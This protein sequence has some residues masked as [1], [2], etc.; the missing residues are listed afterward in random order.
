MCLFHGARAF[1]RRNEKSALLAQ[2]NTGVE[3]LVTG[4]VARPDLPVA[5][6]VEGPTGGHKVV[7]PLGVVGQPQRDECVLAATVK[8]ADTAQI[9]EVLFGDL[10]FVQL[11]VV[12]N[13]HGA[14]EG[15]PGEHPLVIADGVLPIS[16]HVHAAA[17]EEVGQTG[18]ERVGHIDVQSRWRVQRMSRAVR[19]APAPHLHTQGPTHDIVVRTL[20]PVG[21]AHLVQSALGHVVVGPVDVGWLAVALATG[22]QHQTVVPLVREAFHLAHLT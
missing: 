8:E 10:P 5:V 2:S 7:I 22:E 17:L 12:V 9:L 4:G 19:E 16:Q 1:V 11:V 13:P 15:I 14:V 18:V 6:I 3:A 20:G 21:D